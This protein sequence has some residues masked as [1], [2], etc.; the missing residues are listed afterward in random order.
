MPARQSESSKG[1][2]PSGTAQAAASV[3][4]FVP[5]RESESS[6]GPRRSDIAQAVASAV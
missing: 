3:G 6:Q 1:P 4:Q 2:R 5:A